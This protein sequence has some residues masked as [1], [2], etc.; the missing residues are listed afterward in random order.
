[1]NEIPFRTNRDRNNEASSFLEY[2]A[3]VLIGI[4]GNS[5]DSSLAPAFADPLLCPL[6]IFKSLVAP[7]HL[8]LTVKSIDKSPLSA[9]L[10]EADRMGS[11]EDN[12]SRTGKK[13]GKEAVKVKYISDPVTVN[14]KDASEFRAIVQELTGKT[15]HGRHGNAKL[16]AGAIS[17][18]SSRAK[19]S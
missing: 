1:M 10:F 9:R 8:I 11:R 4:V 3:L 15:H 13:S 6:S 14:A 16:P 19:T 2:R 17:G 12:E 7:I 5:F 18:G